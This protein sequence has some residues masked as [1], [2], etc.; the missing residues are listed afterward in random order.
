LL[1]PLAVLFGVLL[2]VLRLGRRPAFGGVI[3]HGF[4]LGRLLCLAGC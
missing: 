3:V 4:G 1:L 2:R